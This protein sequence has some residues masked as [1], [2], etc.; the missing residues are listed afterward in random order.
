MKRYSYYALST[1]FILFIAGIV[2][3]KERFLFC[4][5]SFICFDIIRFKSL[6]IEEFRYGSFITQMVPYIAC[7][8]HLPVKF[9]IKGYA[10]SFNLFYLIVGLALVIRYKQYGLAI[11]MSFYYT[12]FVSSS[13]FWTNNEVHQAVAWMFLFLG[14]IV[15]SQEK[16]TNPVVFALTTIVFAGLT[17]F[18]HFIVLIP[19]T[20]LLGWYL[21]EK[22]QWKYSRIGTIGFV[23]L[24][25][26]FIALKFS[27]TKEHSY[28]QAKLREF[29]NISVW[30]ITHS[31]RQQIV[32][33]FLRLC[34]INYWWATAI[35]FLGMY[36]LI[37]YKKILLAVWTILTVIGYL[38]CIGILFPGF[39][40][41][42][43]LFY[44]ESEWQCLGIIAATP[45]VFTALPLL[46]PQTATMLL[47]LIYLT[48]FIYIGSAFGMF[49]YRT[50]FQRSVLSQM[51]KKKITKLG[52][53]NNAP[54]QNLYIMDW[55]VAQ[56][57]LFMSA[58]EN[59]SPMLSFIFVNNADSTLLR[60]L[61]NKLVLD[62]SGD[63][64]LPEQMNYEYFRIDTSHPYTVMTYEELMK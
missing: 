35:F 47:V 8:L 30:K 51:K 1:L 29:S 54:L 40:N 45:F 42:T 62:V 15:S 4:D 5:A 24:V 12:L 21:I 41:P 58:I 20:Y 13:Y 63:M 36:R 32:W 60:S 17:V 2:F 33:H 27:L 61:S 14:Y 9:L 26:I 16:K 6:H 10:F 50:D 22:K 48:R 25:G 57:S 23:A 53:V 28:D 7:K 38:V 19:L 11:L 46:R 52:L 43:P 55:A 34:I 39:K 37:T 56:E 31:L 18:T 64:L 3:Y 44:E 59:D 49:S